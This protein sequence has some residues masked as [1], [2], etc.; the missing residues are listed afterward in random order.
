MKITYDFVAF[1]YI[2]HEVVYA[3]IVRFL[4]LCIPLDSCWCTKKN[5]LLCFFLYY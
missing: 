4:W 5:C 3:R 1:R 2:F